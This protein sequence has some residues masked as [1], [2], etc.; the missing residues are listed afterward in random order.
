MVDMPTHVAAMIAEYA[1]PP[2]RSVWVV[3]IWCDECPAVY[4]FDKQEDAEEY[5]A[6]VD[7][8]NE[9]DDH[10]SSQHTDVAE[11]HISYS[12]KALYRY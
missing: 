6:E 1:R 5:R 9:G 12:A 4:L 2:E 11:C 7:G 3:T 10:E 8:D